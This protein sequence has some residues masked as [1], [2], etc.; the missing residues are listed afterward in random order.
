M[1]WVLAEN[2]GI[3]FWEV[4]LA[5]VVNVLVRL[6]MGLLMLMWLGGRLLVR[7]LVVMKSDSRPDLA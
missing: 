4:R 1:F 2:S 6:L 7:L 5:V 3:S